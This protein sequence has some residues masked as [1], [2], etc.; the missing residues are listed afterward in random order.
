MKLLV[1][2]IRDSVKVNSIQANLR[3]P[4]VNHQNWRWLG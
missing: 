3:T 2:C 1:E 4:F